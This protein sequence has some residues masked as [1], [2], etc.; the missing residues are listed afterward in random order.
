MVMIKAIAFDCGGVILSNSWDD[1]VFEKF[2]KE[3]G[4]SYKKGSEMFYR[5]YDV[6]LKFG[7]GSEDNFFKNLLSISKNKKLEIKD[8]KRLYY[9]K[10][11]EKRHFPWSKN[12]IKNILS[13]H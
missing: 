13:I 4:V 2:C 8:V 7:K 1:P 5:H 3:I 9:E 11:H 6:R 12:Y 10:I